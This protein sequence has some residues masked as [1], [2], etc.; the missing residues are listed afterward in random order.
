MEGPLRG[1]HPCCRKGF[2]SIGRSRPGARRSLLEPLQRIAGYGAQRP[3][4]EFRRNSTLVRTA[5][6]PDEHPA[7]ETA[8]QAPG[9]LGRQGEFVPEAHH[10]RADN[11]HRRG[12]RFGGP[13]VCCVPWRGGPPPGLAELE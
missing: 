12:V 9:A 5:I 13:S 10:R 11:Q 4:G 7:L 8:G 3:L 2:G 6:R 1:C